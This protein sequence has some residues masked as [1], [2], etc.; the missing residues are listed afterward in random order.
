M[1]VGKTRSHG[2]SIK[3]LQRIKLVVNYGDLGVL[4][5]SGLYTRSARDTL[6]ESIVV[7][8]DGS[9]V[10]IKS[11]F[12]TKPDAFQIYHVFLTCELRKKSFCFLMLCNCNV[13]QFER[14]KALHSCYY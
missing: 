12:L 9:H 7:S 8:G 4:K 1:R 3:V 2:Y 10:I 13:V 5:I 11:S 6:F 14:F